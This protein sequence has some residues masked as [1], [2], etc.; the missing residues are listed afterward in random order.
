MMWMFIFLVQKIRP[1]IG[2]QKYHI[3]PMVLH[4]GVQLHIQIGVV[5]M[6]ES[7]KKKKKILFSYQN[8]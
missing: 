6:P 2:G 4:K 5:L 8:F 7:F 3:G 1:E